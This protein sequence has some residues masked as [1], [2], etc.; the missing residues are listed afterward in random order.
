MDREFVLAALKEHGYARQDVDDELNRDREIA[1]AVV[2]TSNS[3]T[4]R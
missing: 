3:R 4:T 2:R 1:L